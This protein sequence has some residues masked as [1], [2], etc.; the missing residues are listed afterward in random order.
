MVSLR[1]ERSMER[2]T[3]QRIAVIA[4]G[5]TSLLVLGVWRARA[6]SYPWVEVYETA[7][8]QYHIEAGGFTPGT[9]VGLGAFRPAPGPP[10]VPAGRGSHWFAGHKFVVANSFGEISTDYTVSTNTPCNQMLPFIACDNVE[11]PGGCLNWNGPI[12]SHQSVTAEPS[13][14]FLTCP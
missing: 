11:V 3:A 2:R 12:G 13:Y 9:T 6:T 8:R 5:V 14:N 10:P 4:V 7:H 1:K